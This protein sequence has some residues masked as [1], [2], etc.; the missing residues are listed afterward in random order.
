MKPL[1]LAGVA[2]IVLAQPARSEECEMTSAAF[3]SV[4]HLV[5]KSEGGYFDD[6][7]GGPTIHGMRLDVYR[8]LTGAPITLTDFK[9]LE[10]CDIDEVY[11][12]NYWRTAKCPLLLGE[13]GLAAAYVQLDAAINSGPGKARKLFQRAV[14][15]REDGLIGPKTMWATRR[16][17]AET[18]VREMLQVRLDFMESI[19]DDRFMDGWKQRIIEVAINAGK[20]LPE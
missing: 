8:Q 20:L 2:C 16:Y 5:Y 19:G 13:F 11:Y 1:L 12:E 7:R 10:P 4:K 18:L 17:S 6:P 14:G 9:A 3:D 15:A